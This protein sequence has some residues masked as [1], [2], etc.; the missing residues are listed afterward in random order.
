GRLVPRIED[1]VP[2]HIAVPIPY[3]DQIVWTRRRVVR[4]WDR[5]DEIE[6]EVLRSLL[7]GI[8][9]AARREQPDDAEHGERERNRPGHGRTSAETKASNYPTVWGKSRNV[10][11]GVRW[12]AVNLPRATQR[13]RHRGVA[14]ARGRIRGGQTGAC[15]A[16]YTGTED[17]AVESRRV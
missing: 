8:V 17:V 12:V 10:A 4:R 13:F 16:N 2:V 3:V 5:G 6:L 15:M 1:S 7:G 11:R 14:H 9:A